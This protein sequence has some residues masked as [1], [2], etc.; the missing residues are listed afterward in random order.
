MDDADK[1]DSDSG[2]A[3]HLGVRLFAG[4][5]LVA[6]AAGAFA[7]GFRTLLG[8]AIRLFGGTS[9]VVSAARRAPAWLRLLAP[10]AG[11]LLAGLLGLATARSRMGQGV[12]DVMEAAVLRRVHL[13]MRVSLLKSL[14]SFLAIVTGG[15]L[16]REGPLI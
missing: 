11:G 2:G 7:V 9:D 8:M 10:A 16:G 3:W 5:L 1:T 4:I 15:S 14:A 13:S 12:G 6:V